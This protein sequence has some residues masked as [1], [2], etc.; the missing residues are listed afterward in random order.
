MIPVCANIEY[1][2]NFLRFF[3][4]AEHSKLTSLNSQNKSEATI[5]ILMVFA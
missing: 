2:S 4:F 3:T 1:K 5:K